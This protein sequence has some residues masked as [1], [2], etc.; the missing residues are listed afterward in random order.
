MLSGQVMAGVLSAGNEH[1]ATKAEELTKDIYDCYVI[2][3]K[4]YDSD[5][6]RKKLEAQN[7]I[8]VIPG[9]KNRK[10][11]IEY[12]K[13]LYKKRNLIERVFGKIKEN[14]R[15][16]VRFEKSDMIF[17]AFITIAFLKINLC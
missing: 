16:A 8:P 17:L 10:I 13:E 1:D 5:A 12:D 15:L 6:N 3:D 2:E 7:N 9:R 4:G 14:R 11:K